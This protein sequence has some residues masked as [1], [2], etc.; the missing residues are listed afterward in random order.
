MGFPDTDLRVVLLHWYYYYMYTGKIA[1]S[2]NYLEKK[3][4]EW[5]LDIS[6][7]ALAHSYVQFWPPKM[8]FFLKFFMNVYIDN[9]TYFV[10][11][12]VYPK[13]SND[14]ASFKA[15]YAYSG[16]RRF[17]YYLHLW[18]DDV[19]WGCLFCCRRIPLRVLKSLLGFN[20]FCAIG[21]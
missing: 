15:T 3:W 2:I 20:S 1:M 18:T 11:W 13:F 9:T 12:N 8:Y 19:L 6:Y 5:K 16:V 7:L 14:V 21:K 4:F 17:S 10:G